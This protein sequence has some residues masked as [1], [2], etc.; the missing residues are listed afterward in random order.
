[1]VIDLPGLKLGD[2]VIIDATNMKAKRLLNKLY[3]KKIGLVKIL[4]IIGTWA[5]KVELPPSMRVHNGS[6][7]SM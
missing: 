4:K 6:H 3:H 7:V 5:F 2:L 1:M